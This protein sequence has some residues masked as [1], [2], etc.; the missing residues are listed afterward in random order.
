MQKRRQEEYAFKFPRK[1]A[2]K[3]EFLTKTDPFQLPPFFR[4]T[5]KRKYL[6]PYS[7]YK[8]FITERIGSGTR[9]SS[10]P[11]TPAALIISDCISIHILILWG[12]SIP[13]VQPGCAKNILSFYCNYKDR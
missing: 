3:H 8:Y 1:A 2:E 7:F 13:T 10:K 12:I 5:P 4:T 11:G 6:Y 9:S